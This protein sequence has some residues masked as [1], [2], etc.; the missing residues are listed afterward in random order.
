MMTVQKT[1]K[2]CSK[3]SIIKP[4]I[5]FHRVNNLR[6]RGDCR[7]CRKISNAQFYKKNKQ[8]SVAVAS[9]PH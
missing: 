4:I 3:C 7:S 5:E 8:S 1:E 6:R 2:K 9:V